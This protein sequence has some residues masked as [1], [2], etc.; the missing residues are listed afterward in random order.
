MIAPASCEVGTS[1]WNY[2]HWKSRF[3]PDSLHT[4]EWLA[5]YSQ[6][7]HTVEINTTHY[8]LPAEASFRTWYAQT[9]ADFTFAVKASRFITHMKK[10]R[11]VEEPLNLFLQRVCGLGDKLGPILYQL[12]P[13][14][15]ANLERLEQFLKLLPAGLNHVFEFR[16]PSWLNEQVY[17]LLRRYNAT[18][19]LIA[20]PGFESPKVATAPLVYIRMHGSKVKYG[21]RFP[22]DELQQWAALINRFLDDGHEVLVYFNNDAK[23]FAVE[24]AKELCAMVERCR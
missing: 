9:P 12:P 1:G 18:L 20:L 11:D 17:S 19:C 22:I 15:H 2:K 21:D 24:N 3:Y 14:W 10:L 5:F 13:F 7:F 8:H 16:H 6:H 23:A 4:E